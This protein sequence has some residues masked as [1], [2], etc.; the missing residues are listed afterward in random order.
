MNPP[1]QESAF[2]GYVA[3]SGQYGD[4]TH[5]VRIEQGYEM[6]RPSLL[7]LTIT[8]SAGSLTHASIAGSAVVVTEGTIDA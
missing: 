7:E 3:A 6:G 8:I 1:A 4:G 2:A 5:V